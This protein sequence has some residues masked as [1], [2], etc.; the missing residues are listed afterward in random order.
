MIPVDHL[1]CFLCSL[2]GWRTPLLTGEEIDLG[3]GIIKKRL[4]V[5]LYWRALDFGL[6]LDIFTY[7]AVG[8]RLGLRQRGRNFSEN[9]VLGS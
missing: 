1:G 3:W 2:F 8:G 6:P 9:A 7:P 5:C 4:L